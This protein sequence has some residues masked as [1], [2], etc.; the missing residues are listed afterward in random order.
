MH[1]L[2]NGNY[3]YIEISLPMEKH[4]LL[5]SRLLKHNVTNST[6]FLVRKERSGLGRNEV[7]LVPLACKAHRTLS[8]KALRAI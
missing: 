6:S 2:H 5:R 7:D 1:F 3:M 8:S 4:L